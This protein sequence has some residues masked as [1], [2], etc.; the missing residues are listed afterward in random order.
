MLYVDPERGVLLDEQIKRELA[1]GPYARWASD[2][3]AAMSRGDVVEAT[4]TAEELARRQAAHGFTKEDL[5]MVLKPMASDGHEPVFSMGDDSPLPHLAGRPRP[6]HHYLRQR[7]AQVTNPPIDSVRERRVM[8]LRTLLGP[9]QPILTEGPEAAR[10]LTMYS[11]FLYPSAVDT[12]YDQEQC[13]FTARP[14]DTT[15]P[16]A[17]GPG[18]LRDAVAR[19]CDEAEA[20]VRDGVGVV[21]LDPGAVGPDRAPVP[22]LL[23]CGAVHHRLTA[24]RLRSLTSLVVISDSTRDT[25]EAA[26]HLGYGADALCPRLALETVALEADEDEGDVVS[27]EAQTRF[28]SAIEEGVLKVLSK[29][30]I[31]TVDS[32]RG[33]QIF[34]VIGLADEVVD[35]SFAGTPSVVG[36]LGWQALGEDA[37]A[38]HAAA[39][40]AAS[41]TP[42][43]LESPGF[44][45]VRKGGEL[46]GKSKEVV[47]ALNAVAL[48]PTAGKQPPTDADTMVTAAHLLQR[49]IKGGSTPTYDAYAAL[50]NG[51]PPIELHDLLELVPSPGGP[52]PLD[53]V[54]PATEI[55]RRFS[56]GAMSHG[57]LSR[58]AHETLSEAMNLIGGRSNCGEGGEDPARFRTRGQATGDK[59]SRIKQ[60]A[61]GR[62]GV[63]P[64]YTAHADELQIKVAQAPSPAR[65]AS[66][67]ATR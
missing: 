19:L 15:F 29:M 2:G 61:S 50:V 14:L 42:V 67:P 32:Y 66:C 9:R 33:A 64:E 37:L 5:A 27:Y 57:S 28:Q 6:L 35:V 23:A 40:P 8:S 62:F 16:V 52:V 20:A 22:S 43:T 25:H 3:L 36:G 26:A 41:E 53:E 13:P 11:F 18:G 7:F 46:H 21:V 17:E 47:D 24:A 31:A 10:L 60:I 39:W 12:L 54:E 56:T 51:R 4:P 1:D 49:A 34:E 48:V 44:I 59:S 55:V 65:A 38:R 63:T 58:E 45:R 30:G